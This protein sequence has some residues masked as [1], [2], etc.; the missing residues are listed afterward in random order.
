MKG[1]LTLA[2]DF[3]RIAV[4]FDRA[5]TDRL[6]LAMKEAKDQGRESFVFEGNEFLVAYAE[7]LVEYLD[8]YLQG[9]GL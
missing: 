9:K 3:P 5:K 8:G 6:K 1:A 4:S 7:Y 2:S